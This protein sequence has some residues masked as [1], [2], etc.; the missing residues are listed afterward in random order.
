MA[1]VEV[2]LTVELAELKTAVLVASHTP[3][4]DMD[5]VDEAVKVPLMHKSLNDVVA[6]A[7]D[8]E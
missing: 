6:A 7:F 4:T 3:D 1:T 5:W 2:K 8:T